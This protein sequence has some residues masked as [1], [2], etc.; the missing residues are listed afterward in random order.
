[1]TLC[2]KW[3]I[4]AGERH[5]DI[6]AKVQHMTARDMA[7]LI[8]NALLGWRK[9]FY[10]KEMEEREGKGRLDSRFARLRVFMEDHYS[11]LAEA[12]DEDILN[13]EGT[14]V[15][16]ALDPSEAAYILLAELM[17][18]CGTRL[19]GASKFPAFTDLAARIV[20]ERKEDEWKNESF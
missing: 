4:I 6:M 1:M 5:A 20:E 18:L 15:R 13:E 9:C 12:M 3:V 10:F 8:N 17:M 2:V 19:P 14:P 11:Y 7:I 16:K